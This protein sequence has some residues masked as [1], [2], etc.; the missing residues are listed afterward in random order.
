MYSFT[1][2]Q[3]EVFLEICRVGNFSAAA[4]RLNVTQPAISNV[5]RALESQ[6]GVELFERRRG[7]S[8]VLTRDGAGFRDSAQQFISQCELI[9]RN[10]RS[11]RR[12]PRPLRV[13]VGA[14]ILE[15]YMRPLLPEF[16]EENPDLQLNFLPEKARDHI[17]QDIVAR[18]VDV[19]LVTG[20]PDERPAHSLLVGKVPTGVFGLRSFGMDLTPQGISALPFVLPA[21]GT[22]LAIAMLREMQRHGIVPLHILG[23]Y[24]HHDV[25][26][27]VACRGKGVVFAAQSVVDRHDLRRQLRLLYPTADWERHLYIGTQVDSASATA[28]A[29]FFTR[30]LAAATA[31]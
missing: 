8:C 6:L 2:R 3:I 25:R 16:Y 24:P 19:A 4:G 11:T 15:D 14:H 22:Q 17:L 13:F 23:H 18:K 21:A 1:F 7:T 20:P 28:I 27:R 26:I 31:G 12:K 29:D 10:S 30:A 9:G 5:I